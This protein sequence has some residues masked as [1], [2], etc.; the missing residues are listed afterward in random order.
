[1][2][3]QWEG[4]AGAA[5]ITSHQE[6]ESQTDTR[7]QAV[8]SKGQHQGTFFLQLGPTSKEAHKKYCQLRTKSSSRELMGN[9]SNSK[10]SPLSQGKRVRKG[11][12]EGLL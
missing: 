8:T 12:L 7:S 9:I 4:V 6:A 11:L 3:L 5:Y 10:H 1:M 2:S